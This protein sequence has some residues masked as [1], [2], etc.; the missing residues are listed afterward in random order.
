MIT[1][2]FIAVAWAASGA[3][4]LHVVFSGAAVSRV[5]P[6]RAVRGLVAFSVIGE[7]TI[8]PCVLGVVRWV[9]TYTSTVRVYTHWLAGCNLARGAAIRSVRA[10]GAIAILIAKAVFDE[11]AQRLEGRIIR[12]TVTI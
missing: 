4:Y 9:V 1:E 5:S 11:L 3:N 10:S 12:Y 2:P 6:T 8:G 7:F